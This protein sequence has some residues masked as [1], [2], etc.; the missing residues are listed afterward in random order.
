MTVFYSGRNKATPDP[1]VLDKPLIVVKGFDISGFV[2]GP[3]TRSTYEKFLASISNRDN[4]YILNDG[5]DSDGYDIVYVDFN[6]GTDYIQR[7]AYLL[8][9]VIRWAATHRP[10][11]PQQAAALAG[12]TLF[13]SAFSQ[14]H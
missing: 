4:Q 12:A 2:G 11:G 1:A 14:R 3:D 6:N 9:R 5:A 13:D 10:P 8:E 7:N